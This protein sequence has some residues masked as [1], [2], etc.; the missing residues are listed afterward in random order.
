VILRSQTLQQD[1]LQS[2]SQRKCLFKQ[3]IPPLQVRLEHHDPDYKPSP[4]IPLSSS[5][6]HKKKPGPKPKPLTERAVVNKPVK[7]LQR[8]YSRE[9]KIQVI[10]FL[11]RRKEVKPRERQNRRRTGPD[12]SDAA[13]ETDALTY[14]DV[15]FQ[16][17]SQFF[18]IPVATLSDWWQSRDDI[19]A[20]KRREKHDGGA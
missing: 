7:R 20:N 6:S 5:Q 1:T 11:A 18:K 4:P 14:G 12:D 8:R 10:T 13:L 3:P 17:A 16:E 9:K 2:D 15:T 19:L